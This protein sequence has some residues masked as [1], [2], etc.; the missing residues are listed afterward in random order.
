MDLFATAGNAKLP[1]FC[2]RGFHPKAW[3]VDAF[4]IPWDGLEAYAFPPFNLIHKVLLKIRASKVRVLLIAP[5]WP[6][7]P[8]FPLLLHLVVDHPL[9]FPCHRDLVS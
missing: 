6:R 1:T 2:S 3:A 7:Q 9:V 4:A 8:W 5:M